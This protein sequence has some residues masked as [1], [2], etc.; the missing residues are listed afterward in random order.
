MSKAENMNV[1]LFLINNQARKSFS[2]TKS[3]PGN[4][5]SGSEKNLIVS[6]NQDCMF[7]ESRVAKCVSYEK[8]EGPSNHAN[9]DTCLELGSPSLDDKKSSC[10][11][12]LGCHP[13]DATRNQHFGQL[14]PAEGEMAGKCSPENFQ[15]V[16][17]IP[18]HHLGLGATSS[19]FIELLEP[20]STDVIVESSHEFLGQHFQKQTENIDCKHLGRNSEAAVGSL[21][22]Q[23]EPPSEDLTEQ[24]EPASYDA[25][26]DSVHE[27]FEPTPKEATMDLSL[28]HLAPQSED[29]AK[30]LKLE[31]LEESSGPYSMGSELGGHK[32]R[33]NFAKFQ[34]KTYTLR[35][36]IGSTRVLRSRLQDKPKSL[37]LGN[38]VEAFRTDGEK[39]RKR[40][41][42]RVRR[43]STDIFS[44]TKKHLKYLLHRMSYEQN[45]IDVY[46]GEGWKGQSLEKIKLEKELQRAA[47]E[48]LRCKLKIRD[49]FQ[50]LDLSCA[51][52]RLPESLFDSEGQIDSEDIF[53]AKCGSKDLS[54][55]NDII[56]C[57]GACERGFHQ[58]CLEP[59]LLKEQIPPGD[60]GWLCPGCDCKVDCFDLLND[61]QGTNLDITDSCEKVFPEASSAAAAGDEQGD[62]LGSPS[63]DSEDDD[64]DP[65][66]QEVDDKA[67]EDESTS[68]ESND[69]SASDGLRKSP[70]GG[71]CLVLPSDDSGD[72]DY[73]P[74][75]PDLDEQINQE[76]SSSDF[77]SDSEDLTAA[78]IDVRLL[79]QDECPLPLS[80]STGSFKGSR[81]KFNLVGKKKDPSKDEML[82][83]FSDFDKDNSSSVSGKRRVERLDYKKLHDEAYANDPSSSSDDEE[84]LDTSTPGRTKN[85]SSEA[86]LRTP[87]GNNVMNSMDRRRR[88]NELEDT[89]QS[90]TRKKLNLNGTANSGAGSNNGCSERTSGAKS[91]TRSAYRRLGEAVTQKLY[92]S[93]KEN[94]YPDR[95]TKEN[96]SEALGI[97]VRQ[98]SKWFE[99]ARWSF[100]HPAGTQASAIKKCV[101]NIV[102]PLPEEGGI[103]A[104]PVP[105][106]AT[107][108]A[109][110][111][112]AHQATSRKRKAKVQDEAADQT[113]ST[114]KTPVQGTSFDIP[115]VG[116]RKSGRIQA[117]AKGNGT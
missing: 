56:L 7:A 48:I 65:D 23:L 1:S 55:D 92:E 21:P 109:L 88:Q 69:T 28:G 114:G 8:L 10:I 22:E 18:S 86:S 103:L 57:D 49:L 25:T 85:D 111:E 46:S 83:L 75:A 4:E 17:E 108:A 104:D 59:P 94:Q 51:E 34:K 16:S 93:F 5:C 29:V 71:L 44:K 12:Q 112:K 43:A 100:N 38:Q 41:T 72:D 20:P 31:V 99:N 63:D 84:W 106:V 54:I 6:E 95:A 64:Y 68:Q 110:N 73:D 32:D 102:N 11:E 24:L 61:S 15:A 47:S 30:N 39:K 26:K 77:T 2:P 66:S 116:V 91:I 79:G 53:C 82:S 13:G 35:S 9:D 33:R 107:R 14:G 80:S 81:K 27:Q 45:L 37:V 105:E 96:L 101:E 87:H 60:E 113:S 76:S 89:P 50:R 97:T 67:Q 90:R 19:S 98:V 52:G 40:K 62:R 3:P 117:R 115:N 58:F 36:S 42:K 78:L 70:L 74:N